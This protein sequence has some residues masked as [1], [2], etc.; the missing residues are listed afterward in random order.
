MTA[1]ATLNPV[2]PRRDGK[3]IINPLSRWRERARVR[4]DIASEFP[5]HLSPL[6]KGRGR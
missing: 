2:D 4:V 3:N 1:F 6:P 5:P